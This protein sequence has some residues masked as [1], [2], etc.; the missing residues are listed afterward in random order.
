[1]PLLDFLHLDR[2]AYFSCTSGIL[3]GS[4]ANDLTPSGGFDLMAM[5]PVNQTA[6]SSHGRKSGPRISG[7]WGNA[8]H[9]PL[10]VEEVCM[11]PHSGGLGRGVK[12]ARSQNSGDDDGH[13]I[14][15]SPR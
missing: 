3:S 4:L 8:Q 11:M 1:M 5:M 14:G 9:L 15:V 12:R 13:R 7:S 10:Y 6:P 2:F